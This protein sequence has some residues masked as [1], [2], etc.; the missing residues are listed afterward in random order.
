MNAIRGEVTRLRSTRLPIWVLVTAI[1]CGGVLTGL[2]A[3][4]GPE[5]ATPPM[6]A[7]D[8]AAGAGIVVG[9]GSLLLFVPALI[10]TIAI[11][12]EYRHRTI[13]TTFLLVPRR[14]QVLT[15]KLVVYTVLGLVYGAVASLSAGLM[16]LLAAAVRG[17]RLGVSAD[18]LIIMLT[19]LAL[20]SAVYMMLGVAIGALAR[21]QILAIAIVLGYFYFLENVLMLV[22]GVNMIY[23][24]LPGGATATL[25]SFTFLTDAIADQT[26]MAAAP[27]LPPLVGAAILLGYAMVAAVLAVAVPLRRDLT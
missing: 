20:A 6:P 13:G 18:Q 7:L 27:L 3:F 1:G 2:L 23:P 15:A 24:V 22:P 4:I 5:N 14:G 17:I 26:A 9:I 12:S 19:Q 21:N 16:L 8:T 25:T 10:G 11:T